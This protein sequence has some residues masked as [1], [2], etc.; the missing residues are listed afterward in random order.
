[1]IGDRLDTDILLGINGKI[2]T[3]LVLTGKRCRGRCV[4]EKVLRQRISCL[5]VAMR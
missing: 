4:S 1:M 3:L 2:Q 5:V